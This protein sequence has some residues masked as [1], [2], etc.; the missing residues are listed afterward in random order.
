MNEANTSRRGLWCASAALSLASALAYGT[1]Y[2]SF[3]EWTILRPLCFIGMGL[4]MIGL[5]FLAPRWQSKSREL[6]CLLGLAAVLRIALLPA[7]PSD[8][9][10][11]YLWEGKLVA[12]GISPYSLRGD[13]PDL[14]PYRDEQWRLMN[15]K[16]KLTAYPPG[17]LLSFA[18]IGKIAYQPLAYKAAFALVD[19]AVIG[20]ILLLL[21]KRRLP[22]RN[23]GLYA[24]NPVVLV[25]IAG[26]GHFDVLMLAA[27]A[28]VAVFVDR[29]AWL[30]AAAC[31][32][33]A[34]QM[35][36][37]AL[38][39][40][41]YLIWQGRSKA[42]LG[43]AATLVLVSLP[44]ASSLP[45]LF[46]GLYQFGAH[47]DFNGLPNLIGNALGLTRENLHR[48][49]QGLFLISFAGLWLRHRGRDDWHAHWF[50]AA[51]TLLL[52]APS[53][54]FWYFTWVAIPLVFAPSFFWICLCLTQAFYF[55]VWKDYAATGNWDLLDRHSALVWAPAFL[56]AIPYALRLLKG[57]TKPRTPLPPTDDI[58]DDS[59]L[60][61]IPTLNAAD[62]IDRCLSSILPQL[63]PQ[64]K[65]LL[66]DADSTD[67]TLALAAKRGV[68]SV[69]SPRGRGTQILQGLLHANS[70]YALIVHADSQLQPNSI[71]AMLEHLRSHPQVV[72]GCL[73]Q[74]FTARGIFPYRLIEF[75]NEIRAATWG[76]A[77][78]D[79]NQFF[80][81][82]RLSNDRF[83]DQPLMEDVELS[84]RLR[85]TGPCCYLGLECGSDPRKWTRQAPLRIVLVLRLVANYLIQRAFSEQR[86]KAIS[87]RLYQTY[88]GK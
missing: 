48:P 31:L 64:D 75:L 24:F 58:T 41:P 23:A 16:D 39:G 44:F 53:V 7:P 43:F 11:R 57:I 13:H 32:A 26:E 37:I 84:L 69:R 71:D 9:I 63:R 86:A 85:E 36:F 14:A 87:H 88:Y 17:A 52:L 4:G 67:S 82:A 40:L 66:S 19:L 21:Q 10:H 2:S 59:L 18:A 34:T 5:V 12:A 42:A 27:L 28:G 60:V 45:Q 15:N 81:R 83:P 33:I 49:L 3:D 8:D 50:W 76:V 62:T 78:G 25:A 80:D 74:R 35:K 72:G 70:R 47:R 29:K 55:L 1:G 73:G 77:F 20:L 38:L 56:F 79:Q 6:L 54:H 65:V 68:S 22:L 61:V 46:S 51:G 30:L